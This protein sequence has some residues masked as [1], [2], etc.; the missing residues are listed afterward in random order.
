MVFIGIASVRTARQTPPQSSPEKT[1]SAT[2]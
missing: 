1:L 2:G